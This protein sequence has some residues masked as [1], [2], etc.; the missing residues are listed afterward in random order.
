MI[1]LKQMQ[2][3]FRSCFKINEELLV[4]TKRKHMRTFHIHLF[5]KFQVAT[6]SYL[7]HRVANNNSLKK[8]D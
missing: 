6:E 2:L 5:S 7:I 8:H 4:Q 3:L 1:L